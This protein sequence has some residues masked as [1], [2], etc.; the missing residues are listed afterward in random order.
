MWKNIWMKLEQTV[1]GELDWM[2][3]N[4]QLSSH[5][6]NANGMFSAHFQILVE[7]FWFKTD[8]IL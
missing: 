6:N 5:Y 4:R 7:N 8:N 1:I 2:E 3:T